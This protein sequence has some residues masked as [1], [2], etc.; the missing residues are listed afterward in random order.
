MIK[1]KEIEHFDNFT[2]SVVFWCVAQDIPQQYIDQ[3]KTIDEEYYEEDCFGVCV[4]FDSEGYHMCQDEP[5]SELYYIDNDGN[6][7]WMDKVLTDTEAKTFFEACFE[8]TTHY[9]P[10]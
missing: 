3:A 9:I 10:T 7:H 4:I 1:F 2:D 5:D 6:K 8:E